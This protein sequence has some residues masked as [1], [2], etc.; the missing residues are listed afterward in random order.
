MP[1][2]VD[3]QYEWVTTGAHCCDRPPDR[4]GS[5]GLF[6]QPRHIGDAFRRRVGC[7]AGH[8]GG[9]VPVRRCGH[10]RCRRLRPD[11]RQTGGH[12]AAPGTRNGERVGE[13]AQ[14]PTRA[15]PGRQR[16]RRSRHLPPKARCAIA[17]RHRGAGGL[18]EGYGAST[19]VGGRSRRHGRRGDCRRDLRRAHRHAHPACGPVVERV[20]FRRRRAVQSTPEVAPTSREAGGRWRSSNRDTSSREI[21]EKLSISIRSS[22]GIST[23]AQQ[24]RGDAENAW[25]A[26]G[27]AARRACDHRRGVACGGPHLGSDRRQG[28]RRNF[29]RPAGAGQGRAR[30]P[31][32]RLLRRT[33]T[34]TAQGHKAFDLGRSAVAGGVLRVSEPAE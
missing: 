28:V 21:A 2:R 9:V 1:E 7:F 10:R 6:R 11:R 24:T 23:R 27:P 3:H 15:Q 29:S 33:G 16:R 17:I 26:R 22:K 14:R 4:R 13:P 31:A 19:R 5:R 30:Y 25:R 18:A 8:A 20:G 12:P 32:S 34:G